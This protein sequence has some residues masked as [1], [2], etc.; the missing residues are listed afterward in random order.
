MTRPSLPS[1]A[2]ARA[3]MDAVAP[4]QVR[5][6]ER[7]LRGYYKPFVL[8]AA[9]ADPAGAQGALD[10]LLQVFLVL[11]VACIRWNDSDGHECAF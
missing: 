7:K 2:V 10:L 8:A 6:D 11:A 9:R 3:R 1:P 4:P 5:I